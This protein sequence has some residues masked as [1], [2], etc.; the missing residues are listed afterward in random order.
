RHAAVRVMRPRAALCV[1]SLLALL[2]C[3]CMSADARR[4]RYLKVAQRYMEQEDPVRAILQLRNAL[5]LAPGDVET[6]Y[7]MGLAFLATGDVRAGVAFLSKAAELNPSHVGAQTKLIELMA[8][9]HDKSV[10]RDAERKAQI[11]IGSAPGNPEAL[12]ALATVEV[13]MGKAADAVRHLEEALAAD[14]KHLKSSIT[15]SKIKVWGEDLDGAE[16]V[17]KRAIASEP[18]S[19]DPLIA[20][21]NLYLAFDRVAESDERFRQALAIDPKNREALLASADIQLRLG[22]KAEA[23]A[24]YKKLSQVSGAQYRTTYGEYLFRDGRHSE[25]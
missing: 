23:E 9:S 14:P 10:L 13:L 5:E 22:R 25:A 18:K 24:I 20:L 2:L 15:L 19:P 12:S 11:L 7:Q 8:T 17:L 4:A 1:M 21:A 6:N 16:Q 3:G